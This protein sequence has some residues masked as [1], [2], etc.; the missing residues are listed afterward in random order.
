MEQSRS[1]EA[2]NHSA[3]QEILHLL[4]NPKVHYHVHKIQSIPIH[5]TTFHNE[6]IVFSGNELLALRPSL[7]LKE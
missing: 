4:W 2:N 6:L 3:S 7:N 5:C 1:S